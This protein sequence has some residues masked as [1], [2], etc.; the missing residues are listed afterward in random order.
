MNEYAPQWRDY[1][2]RFITALLSWVV[3][4]AIIHLTGIGGWVQNAAITA[5]LLLFA[6]CMMWL[7]SFRCP[8]CH[9][10][11]FIELPSNHP[12]AKACVHCGLPKWAREDVAP[13]DGEGS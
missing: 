12:M 10:W 8:R 1:R 4:P 2:R 5:W 11:F 7:F 6:V 13:P 9:E 3:P